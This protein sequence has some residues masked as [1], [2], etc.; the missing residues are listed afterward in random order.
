M[1]GIPERCYVSI[2]IHFLSCTKL[3]PYIKPN[4]IHLSKK[5]VSG[6]K[7]L[8]RI[9]PSIIIHQHCSYLMK[10]IRLS[11]HLFTYLSP[12]ISYLLPALS[13][14]SRELNTVLTIVAIPTTPGSIGIQPVTAPG[15]K[16]SVASATI[17][18]AIPLIFDLFSHC[19]L[20][21]SFELAVDDFSDV[22]DLVVAAG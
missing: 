14:K 3:L 16:R 17:L 22:L 20:V 2:Y 5:K 21:F 9:H 12:R 4:Y 7:L 15:T 6:A 13:H 10:C 11:I 1:K 18:N 19:L 8:N